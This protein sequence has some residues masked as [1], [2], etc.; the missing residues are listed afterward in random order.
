MFI[1]NKQTGKNEKAGILPVTPNELKKIDKSGLFEFTWETENKKEVYKVQL[2]NTGEVVGLISLKDIPTE[3]R[4]EI[5][6]LESSKDNVGTDKKY[7]AIAGRLIAYACRE[8]FKRGYFGFVSL[9]PKTKLI[10][11]YK[12]T[13]GFKQA[14]RQLYTEFEN[15][16]TLI[17]KYLGG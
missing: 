8:A 3:L 10:E 13:Y 12:A 7:E 6:L 9:T 5:Y 16:E 4:I 11:H 2:E 15:S 1:K 14:G 17:K